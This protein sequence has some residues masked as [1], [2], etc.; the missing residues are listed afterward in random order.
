VTGEEQNDK[1]VG[2]RVPAGSSMF[3]SFTF[4]SGAAAHPGS[5]PMVVWG[6]G[7]LSLGLK[8]PARE[9]DYSLPICVEVKTKWIYAA[10]L[11]FPFMA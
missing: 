4:Q 1:R 9:A 6:G 7:A 3:S 8:R 5:Y 10:T 2:V 11:T